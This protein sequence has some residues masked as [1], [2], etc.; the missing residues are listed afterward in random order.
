VFSRATCSGAARDAV[1][2]RLVGSVLYRPGMTEAEVI[3][4]IGERLAAAVPA[5]SQM[6]LFRSYQSSS[7]AGQVSSAANAASP[8]A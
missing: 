7:R 5:G 1:R 3:T 6:V 2:R 4:E 8:R